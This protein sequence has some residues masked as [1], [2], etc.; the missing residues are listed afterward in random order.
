MSEQY[1]N[2]LRAQIGRVT[3]TAKADNYFP[4]TG[5]TITINAQTKW[6][7]TSEWQT[8]DGGGNTVTTAGKLSLQKDSK[9]ITITAAGELQQKFIARNYLTE[10]VVRKM[11]YAMIPQ[12]LPYFD[13]TAQEVVRVGETDYLHVTMENGYTGASEI[14]VRVYKENEATVYKVLQAVGRPTPDYKFTFSYS[15]PG[16]S[17]RGIYDVEVDV[18]DTTSGITFA[19]KINKLI[20]V[21]PKLCPKPADTSTGYEVSS[22]YDSMTTYAGK[23]AFEIR[24]WRNVDNT[25]LNYAEAILPHGDPIASYE[26]MKIGLLPAGTT[27]CLKL[28]PQEPEPYACRFLPTGTTEANLTNENGSPNFSYEHPLVIT[29]DQTEVWNWVWRYYGALSISNNLRNIV[30]DGL[31]YN[32]TGI[33]FTPLPGSVYNTCIFLVGG[34]SDWEMF[35]CDVDDTGFAGISAKTDPSAGQPWFWRE[36]GWE[37]TNLKIHH[38]T[39]QNTAGEGVY[40]GYYGTGELTG[41][42]HPHLLRGLRLYRCNFYHTGFD[43]VQINNSVETEV[44]YLSIE[45]CC[46]KKEVNQANTFSCTMDGRVYN[47][48]VWDNYS[49]IGIMFPFMSKLEVFNNILTCDK[50]SLAFSWTRWS[51]DNTS[52]ADDTLVFSIYNNVIKGRIIATIAG[53]IT[54][55]N[56]TMNDNVFIT[57]E[58]DTELPGYFTGSGNIFI[59]NNEEY[60]ALDSYLKVADSA[61][62]N[63]QPNYNSMLVSAGN[64]SLIEY[65]MRGYKRWYNQIHHCGPFMGIYKDESLPDESIPLTLDSIALSAANNKTVAVTFNYSGSYSPVKYRVGEVAN[66]SGIDWKDYSGNITYTFASAGDKTLYGQL[67]DAEGNMT[68]IKSAPITIAEEAAHKAVIS[69][70]WVKS[71]INNQSIIFDEELKINK[72]NYSTVASTWKW[73]DGT[74]G[75]TILKNNA[76]GIATSASGGMPGATTGDDSGVYPDAVLEKNVLIM[77][78][79]T[80]EDFTTYCEALISGLSAG[81]YKIRL[82]NSLKSTDA[83]LTFTAKYQIVV[84]NIAT[85]FI[86]PSSYDIRNN[87]EQWLELEV[88]VEDSF[89]LRWGRMEGKTGTHRYPVN[90]IEI[91]TV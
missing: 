16:A 21:T 8:Q 25:G 10:T 38:C 24:L 18:K 15:F 86:F 81:K 72:V 73:S 90:I 68:A 56:F 48:K 12:V 22:T 85:D 91:E 34:T 88:E 76:N 62:Y 1:Q 20:T 78:T 31:G 41:G 36:N 60:D 37:M 35:G 54:Y 51:D 5:K 74:D 11:I 53:N 44:C 42:F 39:F 49:S 65:D 46:Y 84:G 50:D 58:G 40:I 43:P 4:V 80:E 29:H 71:E 79:G 59:Q 17:D 55:S 3:A 45:Q 7:Q 28:D 83:S 63:Y 82:Y 77:R 75:G 13:V 32:N 27:L 30:F 87:L 67:Q 19:K 33:K 89:L 23:K 66:L 6:G 70:G 57:S 64:N 69:I 47:C 52:Q 2:K 61:N 14:T 9:E 26:R